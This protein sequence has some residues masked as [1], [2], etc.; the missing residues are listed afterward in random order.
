MTDP[1]TQPLPNRAPKPWPPDVYAGDVIVDTAGRHAVVNAHDNSVVLALDRGTRRKY[2]VRQARQLALQLWQAAEA[3]EHAQDSQ[4]PRPVQ[5]P[6]T[7]T[8]KRQRGPQ[9]R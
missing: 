8:N 9:A 5:P 4:P 6:T 7:K 1:P 3:L 2:T